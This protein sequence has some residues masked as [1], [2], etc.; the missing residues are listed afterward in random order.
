MEDH[1]S[2]TIKALVEELLPWVRTRGGKAR[3]VVVHAPEG[4]FDTLCGLVIDDVD[5]KVFSWRGRTTKAAGKL[6]VCGNCANVARAIVQEAGG[7][8][9]RIGEPTA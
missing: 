8:E 2:A 5:G 4:G 9:R 1:R 7:M 3:H 6:P